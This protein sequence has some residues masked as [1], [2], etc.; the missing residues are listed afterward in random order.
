MHSQTVLQLMLAVLLVAASISLSSAADMANAAKDMVYIPRGEFTMGSNEHADEARH[1]V[2]VDSYLIDKYEA[3][4]ARYK[5]FMNATGHPA[6]AYWDDP[7][8]SQ[9]NQPVVGVSWTD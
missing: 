2:V 6:P 4:N 1:Q 7:R 5:E 9:P 3:S 8:L